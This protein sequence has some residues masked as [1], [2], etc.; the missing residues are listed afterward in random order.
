MFDRYKC[1]RNLVTAKI[2]SSKKSLY[3]DSVVNNSNNS[4]KDMW[5]AIKNILPSKPLSEKIPDDL[6]AESFNL[7]FSTIGTKLTNN[8]TSVPSLPVI[9]T[10][11]PNECFNLRHIGG[12]IVE[13]YLAQLP[14]DSSL[15]VLD[16][17]CKMLNIAAPFIYLSLTHTLNLT[18][19]SGKLP[20]D[21]KIARVTPIYK[22]KGPVN[23][24]GNYRPISVVATITK[25]LESAI[26][27]QLMDFLTVNNIIS[28]SQFAYMKN[29]STQFALH[30]LVDDFLVD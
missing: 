23:D 7:Y 15:D 25:L 21:F 1:Y 30:V 16:I 24:H 2:R 13:R 14:L 28:N 3:V 19:V 27:K 17:D 8:D 26:K 18:V 4:P 29:M 22:G 9:N 11:A 5:K 6:N 20:S 10:D 12:S